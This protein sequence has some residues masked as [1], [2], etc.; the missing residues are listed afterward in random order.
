MPPNAV[1]TRTV[2]VNARSAML[3][4]HVC[5]TIL[6]PILYVFWSGILDIER[7]YNDISRSV[8]RPLSGVYKSCVKTGQNG[9]RVGVSS[10][11]LASGRQSCIF[12]FLQR[13]VSGN[14]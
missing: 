12:Y 4:V 5:Y 3:E 6:S 7:L 8:D 9:Q 11:D 10:G 1:N 14:Q 2:M 13:L